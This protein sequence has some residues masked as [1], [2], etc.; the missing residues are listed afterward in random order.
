MSDSHDSSSTGSGERVAPLVVELGADDQTGIP[1]DTFAQHAVVVTPRGRGS[2]LDQ[3]YVA[4]ECTPPHSAKR[5]SGGLDDLERSASRSIKRA[6]AQ[7]S[8][9]YRRSATPMRSSGVSPGECT[10]GGIH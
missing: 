10:L 9:S 5:M 2:S 8:A 6:H 7:T 4:L 3:S 1:L